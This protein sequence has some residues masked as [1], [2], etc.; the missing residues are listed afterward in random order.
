VT[1]R[2]VI[3]GQ[4]AQTSAVAHWGEYAQTYSQMWKGKPALMLAKCA[5]AL[6]LRKAFPNDMSG[7]VVD[8]EADRNDHEEARWRDR[9]RRLRD[10]RPGA[11]S[12]RRVAR[13]WRRCR[14]LLDEGCRDRGA[15]QAHR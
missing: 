11:S 10:R 2:K 13:P 4:V 3:A 6:A 1:V 15:A 5:E 7:L 9:R 14:G 12:A 8:A